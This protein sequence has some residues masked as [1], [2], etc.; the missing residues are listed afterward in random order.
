MPNNSI[1]QILHLMEA[2]DPN[3]Q[4]GTTDT[5]M[6]TQQLQLEP[7]GDVIPGTSTN[8]ADRFHA[9]DYVIARQLVAQ[10]GGFE[11]AQQLLSNLEQVMD[12]LEIEDG[13]I[14]QIA[15]HCPDEL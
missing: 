3:D 4:L 1:G 7:Y 11:R 13:H 10:V 5:P 9:N 8:Q 15:R 2:M 12:T 14:D 6:A